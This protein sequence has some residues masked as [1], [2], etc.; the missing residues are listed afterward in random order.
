MTVASV[1]RMP[2]DHG[3]VRLHAVP[4]RDGHAPRHPQRLSRDDLRL[5]ALIATG[6]PISVVAGRLGISDRTVRRKVRVICDA[7]GVGTMIEA[8]V[9]AA[10]RGLI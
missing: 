10:R 4:L 7:L 6:V 8:V 2:T 5:I 9:W 1:V 3:T